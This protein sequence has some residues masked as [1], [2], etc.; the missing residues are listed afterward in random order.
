MMGPGYASGRVGAGE[1][2][3]VERRIGLLA[4]G[5]VLVFMLFVLK[6]FQLQILEGAIL[7][8]RSKQN[9][10][11]TVR[12]EAPRGEIVD[13]EGRV[14]AAN[15]PAFGVGVIPSELRSA[16]LTYRVLGLLLERDP[17][18]LR[19][20]VSQLRGRERYQPVV[21]DADLPPD[22]RARVESHR[23]AL[24]GVITDI[25]PRRL[26]V[27]GTRAAHLLG[28]IGEIQRQQLERREFSGYRAGQIVGQRGVEAR[29]EAHLRGRA[30]GRNLV[31]DVEGR[32]GE[33]L[34]RVEPTP[35]GRVILT[36]DLDLQRVAEAGFQAPQPRELGPS[37]QPDK[38][39]ALVALDPRNGEVLALVSRPAYDP[40][41]FA[42][43]IDADTWERLTSDE[44]RPLQDRALSGLY[45]PGSTYKIVVAAAGLSE[46][47]ITP[48]EVLFCPGSYRLG[49]RSYRCWRRGGHGKVDL[50]R[51]L[52]ESCD[53]YFYQLGMR[54][55]I[56]RLAK[57]ARGFGLG[58]PT[59]IDLPGEVAGLVPTI[60]WKER[61][62]KESWLRGETVSASI[63]Q[64][65][66]LVTP[67]Q[68]AV[69]YAALANGGQLVRPRIIMRLERW[70]GEL[71]EERSSAPVESVPVS[72]EHLALL[73]EALT[74]AVQ[75]R[76][77]TGTRARVA[78]LEVAG[79]T[80]TSQV[81]GL[82]KVAGLKGDDIPL[83]HRDHALFAG[84][85]PADQPEIVVVA[86]V[87]HGGAG[88]SV[89][90]PLVQR[91]LARFAE[92]REA[93]LAR[94]AALAQE[95]AAEST[96]EGVAVAGN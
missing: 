46:G 95:N 59:G 88:G 37:R 64:G 25:R 79:K 52:T 31:V 50:K 29:V 13:R 19:Q 63:G 36:L 66:N 6:L 7:R 93:R 54:L 12:L 11:R 43:G 21:L 20:R 85:A 60:E 3:A 56:E 33:E 26:Y 10:V 96:E 76:R 48:E 5:I 57:Y 41:D 22:L 15:R 94:E 42:G 16:E 2:P 78:G 61:V 83:R 65:Y 55:G 86:V 72:P 40:N 68:L 87:E 32:E 82:S 34:G 44:W 23:H 35:G 92:K 1:D 81:V 84:F 74:A 62:R 49:R 89:A 39:G 45:P 73:R 28:S 90:A 67:L 8:S 91:V 53:V 51:A 4:V 70:Q 71:V 77:G 80:G 30:G 24:P 69:A 9:S 38:M 75:S 27:E 14:L 17:E 18:A 47:E 58:R